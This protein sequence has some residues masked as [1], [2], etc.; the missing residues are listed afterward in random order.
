[1]DGAEYLKSFGWQHG[2]ALKKGGIKKPILL[3]HKNNTKGLG[4][5]SEKVQEAWWERVFDGQLK[6]LD[7]TTVKTDDGKV[8]IGA[9]FK[10]NDVA[11]SAISRQDSPLYKNFIFGGILQG[12]I[13][14]KKAMQMDPVKNEDEEQKKTIV[15]GY[16]NGTSN[17]DSKHTVI[18]FDDSDDESESESESEEEPLISKPEEEKS[19]KPSKKEKKEKKDKKRKQSDDE[20]SESS[21]SGDKKKSKK[22]KSKADKTDKTDKK[23]K[24]DKKDKASKKLKKDKSKSNLAETEPALLPHLE[25]HKVSKEEKKSKKDKKDKKDKKEKKSKRAQDKQHSKGLKK[26]LEKSMNGKVKD[27]ETKLGDEILKDLQNEMK[28]SK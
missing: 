21:G 15:V 18:R 4:H 24:R 10:K 3:R 20:S 28:K 14:K 17:G 13:G 26:I 19:S 6:G 7:V 9:L 12:T 2:Q 16:E 23:D 27:E 8:N 25:E 11:M 5:A 22:S 1:M